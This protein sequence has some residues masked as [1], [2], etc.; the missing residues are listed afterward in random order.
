MR[1]KVPC[2]LLSCLLRSVLTCSTGQTTN[3]G[4]DWHVT[5]VISPSL[6]ATLTCMPTSNGSEPKSCLHVLEPQQTQSH[7][8]LFHFRQE[9]GIPFQKVNPRDNPA[10]WFLMTKP[11]NQ[12]E[13]RILISVRKTL[14]ALRNLYLHS[15]G[16]DLEA[17][18]DGCNVI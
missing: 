15:V 7:S 10:C 9:W 2:T 5:T 17:W 11:N 18:K 12:A 3:Y 8:P 4:H 6:L 13:I 14:P 16:V 1:I